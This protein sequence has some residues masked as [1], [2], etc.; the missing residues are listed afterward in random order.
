M[1]NILRFALVLAALVISLNGLWADG[2]TPAAPAAVPAATEPVLT[3]SLPANLKVE[4]IVSA[5]T[6]AF[7]GLQW[8]GLS[9]Q[10][11]TVTAYIDHHGVK[12]KAWAVCTA[13]EIKFFADYKEQGKGTSDKAKATVERWLRNVEKNTKQ[14]L[15]LHPKKGEKKKAD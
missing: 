5:V 8:I 15:G 1:K 9:T 7:T 13:T 12:V 10:N 14:D 3:T 11:D 4:T 6:N 2:T